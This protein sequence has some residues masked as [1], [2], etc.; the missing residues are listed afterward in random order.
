M[1]RSN[2]QIERDVNN[3]DDDFRI[4]YRV[5]NDIITMT[6]RF[7]ISYIKRM[8]KQWLSIFPRV[9][10]SPKSDTLST[11]RGEATHTNFIV[12]ERTNYC[13]MK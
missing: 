4:L 5:C 6:C 11:F 7:F 2:V 9:D 3:M 8:F 13:S 10:L 1:S 12:I